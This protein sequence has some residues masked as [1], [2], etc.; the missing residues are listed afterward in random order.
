SG[1]N[2]VDVGSFTLPTLLILIFLMFI[3]GS[4]SS[5]AGGIKTS[6]FAVLWASV[7]GT[8]RGRE[9]AQIFKKT[10][11][12]GLIFKA[13]SILI[14]Y[15]ILDL[16]GILLLSLTETHILMLPQYDLLDLAFEEV[17][18]FSTT[19]LSTG[20]TPLL[21]PAGKVIITVS[22]FV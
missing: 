1:L 19:G 2:T 18:A 14:I 10:L 8:I 13:L 4:S 16:V 9:H 11:P 12:T 5:T 17:S 20:I 7:I 3:G 22:M 15:I 21:S 6:T